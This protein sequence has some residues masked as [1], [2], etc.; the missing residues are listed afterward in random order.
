M[1]HY[2]QQALRRL[3]PKEI[4]LLGIEDIE[5]DGAFDYLKLASRCRTQNEFNRL[6]IGLENVLV[7]LELAY[8]AMLAKT[9][10]IPEP[11]RL[12]L[13]RIGRKWTPEMFDTPQRYERRSFSR[14]VILY[15]NPERDVR[16]K[17][18]L[19]A[20]SGNGR[21]MMMP[22]SV[23]LQFLD[24][25]LWDVVVLKKCA[26]N[27]FLLG[28]EDVSTDFRGLVEFVE[29]TV[30]SMQY[31]RVITLGTSSGGFAA[32]WA[33]VLMDADRGIS[34]CGRPPS[35]LPSLPMGYQEAPHG[36][37]L[38]FVYGGDCAQD[39]LSALALLDLFGG[40]LRPVPDIDRH[41]VL[42][43]LLKRGQLAEFL[44]EMLA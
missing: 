20:F 19:V 2:L 35:Q 3:R 1:F 32:T 40:R 6:H 18:L 21:R 12:W 30:S 29:T 7:P 39:H 23:F 8:I 34:V 27:S 42:G 25:R 11:S 17:G 43:E 22:I 4:I 10:E 31:R 16:N 24:S 9:S 36:A 44:D 33:A 14:H 15:Q 13:Q 38:C 41:G 5:P 26:R 28:L 37:D